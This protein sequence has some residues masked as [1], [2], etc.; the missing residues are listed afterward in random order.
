MNS[1]LK[2]A[3][4][5]KFLIRKS[6]IAN[7]GEI[8]LLELNKSDLKRSLSLLID[9]LINALEIVPAQTPIQSK[10]VFKEKTNSVSYWRK[11]IFKK[12]QSDSFAFTN[13]VH[14]FNE[15]ASALLLR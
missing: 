2:R 3:K 1:F 9:L 11:S 6:N 13:S 7:K 12:F 5:K 10:L 15:L 8:F 14:L 4:I